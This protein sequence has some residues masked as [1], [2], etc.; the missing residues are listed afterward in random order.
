MLPF[1]LKRGKYTL[2]FV[3]VHKKIREMLDGHEIWCK[4]EFRMEPE[5]FRAITSY[6]RREVLLQDTSNM[7]IEEHLGIFMYMISQNASNAILQKEFQH[8]GETI[9]RKI[10]EFF[11]IIPTLTQRFVKLPSVNQPHVKITS[12]P[13]IWPYF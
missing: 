3:V 13:R 8:I 7:S 2:L 10:S 6:L 9:H 11:G 1:I 5:I 4:S 12:N